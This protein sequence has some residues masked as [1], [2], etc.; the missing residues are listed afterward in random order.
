[1]SARNSGVP[2]GML[3]V[4]GTVAAGQ[5]V[6]GEG[7]AVLMEWS[8]SIKPTCQNA[9]VAHDSPIVAIAYGPYDNGPLITADTNGVCRV[10]DFTPRLWC[11][12]QVDMRPSMSPKN[13]GPPSARLEVAI[14]S[15]PLQRALYSIAGDKRLLVWSQTQTWPPR[16]PDG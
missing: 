13:D 9:I 2:R 8:L 7:A 5:E 11:S 15:D 6:A 3:F 16:D 4:A 10:W 12:Q 1:G 14:A